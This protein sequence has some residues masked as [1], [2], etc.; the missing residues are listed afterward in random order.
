MSSIDRAAA[1]QFHV[2]EPVPGQKHAT[3]IV[4]RFTCP[5][6]GSLPQH[7]TEQASFVSQPT[8]LVH[9]SERGFTSVPL[10][11][12][13]WAAAR[14]ESRLCVP[15][16]LQSKKS[17]PRPFECAVWQTG[18]VSGPQHALPAQQVPPHPTGVSGAQQEPELQV[19]P[20][21][22]ALEQAPQCS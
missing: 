6:R 17:C 3:L 4:L 8:Q 10:A 16:G 2:G 20:A 12:Q 7:Q 19:I 1:G 14:A 11:F 18:A 13:A 9:A 21:E 5:P 22:H 15:S